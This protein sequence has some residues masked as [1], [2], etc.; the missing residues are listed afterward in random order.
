MRLN[1]HTRYAIFSRVSTSSTR[2]R[3]CVCVQDA[4][5]FDG[6]EQKNE[7]VWLC[8]LWLWV[9]GLTATTDRHTA[10]HHMRAAWRA[11]AF[12]CVRCVYACV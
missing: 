1:I 12:E 7:F 4:R 8:G 10:S 3:C 2:A 5:A 9:C 11:R 6:D